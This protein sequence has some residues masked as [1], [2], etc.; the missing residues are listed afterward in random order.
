MLSG[1]M[2]SGPMLSNRSLFGYWKSYRSYKS[3][4]EIGR[5]LKLKPSWLKQSLVY[6]SSITVVFY[7]R[8]SWAGRSMSPAVRILSRWALCLATTSWTT[9]TPCTGVRVN[10][11]HRFWTWIIHIFFH[12]ISETHLV[13]LWLV[14]MFI[15]EAMKLKLHIFI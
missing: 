1:P 7:S 9:T 10:H 14:L 12:L 2:L 5:L 8:L 6:I 15:V 13:N 11:R 3:P 4:I